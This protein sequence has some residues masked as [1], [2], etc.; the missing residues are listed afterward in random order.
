M[1]EGLIFKFFGPEYFHVEIAPL[2]RD[3]PPLNGLETWFNGSRRGSLTGCL[4][5]IELN[6]LLLSHISSTQG[7]IETK[8][9]KSQVYAS[10]NSQREMTEK[11]KRVVQTALIF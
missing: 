2:A 1:T 7:G 4:N 8:Q 5:G 3:N 10:E 11:T 9:T 6:T